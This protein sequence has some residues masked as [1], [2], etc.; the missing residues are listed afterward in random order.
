ML[1]SVIKRKIESFE[2]QTGVDM[3]YL[4]AM[5]DGSPAVLRKFFMFMPFAQ[6]GKQAPM[7]LLGLVR[8]V[9]A[10]AENCGPCVT[11]NVNFAL[12]SGVDPE[13]LEAVVAGERARLGDEQR[14][15]YDYAWAVCR[16]EEAAEDYR[17]ALEERFGH[18]VCVELAAALASS[19]L[20]PILKRAL[21]YAV[22]HGE[23]VAVAS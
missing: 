8:V 13:M 7:E 15:T 9:A 1:D 18:A 22:P 3:G 2:K 11:I 23:E 21:G 5:Q 14:L 12:A 16:L 6:H 17:L 4:R 19:R 10:L 20:F